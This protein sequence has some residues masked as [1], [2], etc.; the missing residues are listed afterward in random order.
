MATCTYV[1][2]NIVC[3]LEYIALKHVT[4]ISLLTLQ[5]CKKMCGTL[6]NAPLDAQVLAPTCARQPPAAF[7]RR[8]PRAQ[9]TSAWRHHACRWTS[10]AHHFT[11]SS[12]LRRRHWSPDSS[13]VRSSLARAALHHASPLPSQTAIAAVLRKI[14][15]HCNSNRRR[16]ARRNSGRRP[17]WPS[18]RPYGSSNASDER[19]AK[20]L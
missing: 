5:T 4:T 17:L 12:H 3:K 15:Q 14:V 20:C 7:W 19:E 11:V 2:Y 10:P 18:C 9:G 1:R 8:P 6:R 13:M 16:P